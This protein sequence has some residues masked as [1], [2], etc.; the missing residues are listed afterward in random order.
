MRRHLNDYLF[1]PL[2][3]LLTIF[4]VGLIILALTLL[5]P[6]GVKTAAYLA[7]SS[8][9]ELSIKGVSGSLLT[10]LHVDEII[11]DDVD[12]SLSLNDVDLK[13]RHYDTGRKR[14]VAEEVRAGRLNI[15]LKNTLQKEEGKV[16]L[17]D[18]GL[19]LNIN[20]NLLQLDSL[21]ITQDVKGD[22]GSRTLL[23][24]IKDIELKKVTISDGK[25]RFRRLSGKPIILDQPLNINVT[26][27]SLN[28]NYPHDLSTGGSITYKHP[29]FGDVEGGLQL[30]GTLT[31][32]SF[33]GD[34]KHQQKTL[35][36][37]A[38]KFIGEG[39]YRRIH[40]EDVS[41]RGNH[42]AVKAKGRVVFDPEVTWAFKV[43]GK[44]L[45]T[46]K[47]LVDWPATVDA[48]FRY[49]G[50]YSDGRV[51]NN[52]HITSIEGK[53]REY[54]LKLSG[55]ITE[56]EGSLNTD[57]L[58][59]QLGDNQ[60]KV[61]GKASEPYNLTWTVDAP[62]IKQM[63]PKQLADLK[64]S[65]SVKGSGTV[66]G[67]LIKPEISL[68]IVANDLIY[69]DFKQGKESLKLKGD[70]VVDGDALRLKNFNL[71]SGKNK[72]KIS[73]QASEPFDL[74]WKIDAKSLNQVSPQLA[75]S[76]KGNG[77]LKGTLEKPEA[78]I[79][80]STN[81]LVY[82]E[83]KQG[84]ETLNIESEIAVNRTGKGDV[85]QLKSLNVKSGVNTVEASGQAS[86]PF[87]LKW[88]IEA[89]S[90]RQISP[91]LA[92]VLDKNIAGKIVSS[93]SLKGTLKKPDVKIKLT[94]NN[95]E[96]DG[97]K[98]GKETLFVEGD[99]GFNRVAGKDI[100][101]LTGLSLKSGSNTLQVS[102]QA[103]E[104]LKLDVKIN[105]QTLA[106]IS[107][108]IKGSVKG[109]VQIVGHYTSPTMKADLHASNLHYKKDRLSESEIHAKGEV[110]LVDGVPII[111]SMTTYVGKNKILI[112]GRAT[113]PFD[114]TWDIEAKKLHQ[115]YP[116]LSG[117]LVAKGKL[118]G[119]IEKPIINGT[120]EAKNISYQD[121]ILG[122]GNISAQTNNGGLQNKGQ[123][124]KT[125]E[126]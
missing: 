16:L 109:T 27:G 119:T 89:N 51:E 13:L 26:E 21:Q 37:Q 105:A 44:K 36:L 73:G 18:F 35:G 111:K 122:S 64:I 81:G 2:S 50:N 25:L 123:A 63:L 34:V 61:S 78:K 125:T 58:D 42:G 11:W 20:A 97:I 76:I 8:L 3:W 124:G 9:K 75:G 98:Q 86:E 48:D 110:Q 17:P 88:K 91:L 59:L 14:L 43:D 53:L 87:D 69:E 74:E 60:L 94:A 1:S 67:R 96:Y 115:L 49:I 22:E 116:G 46:K 15:N 82:K 80:I 77:I 38:I 5:T 101:Q 72:V 84:K 28:M 117:F 47:L 66:K 54:D 104:P 108:D 7:D 107:P 106:E 40:L 93:G 31:N 100:I 85:I 65:G 113:S 41:L 55:Q 6:F 121:F 57:G 112:S 62:N 24:Q 120:G 103:S 30:A 32:Y 4:I 102:G 39:D 95:L 29:D 19:P 71:E 10:G 56:K 99:L 23:F 90:L 12:N 118:Q 70:L 52:I 79:K 68:D 33:E 83:L 92:S 114:M 126:C 45:S